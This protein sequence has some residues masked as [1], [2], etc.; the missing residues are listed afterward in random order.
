MDQ[1]KI[2]GIGNIY[3]NDALFDAKIL[4]VRSAKSLSK[5]EIKRLFDSIIKVMKKSFE[6]GGA[7]ELSFVNIL[8]QEG[9]YQSHTLVY[10]K[11]GKKCPRCK[12][13]IKRINL[14]GRGTF[15]CPKCQI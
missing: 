15:Y 11:A 7:S 3:A 12:N 8:G 2:G 6:E 13:I 5:N 10:G 14:G 1:S 9:N 4:P